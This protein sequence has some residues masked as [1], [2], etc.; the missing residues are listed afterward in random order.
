LKQWI[1][2]GAVRTTKTRGGHHRVA[3][4]E[5]E[6]LL[7]DSVRPPDHRKPPPK[8]TPPTVVALS[9]R[10]QLRGLIEEVRA[11]GI[12]AQVRMRIGDD[13][14]TAI[15][16]RDAVTALGLKR[17]QPAIALIKST[18]VMIAREPDAWPPAPPSRP[19]RKRRRTR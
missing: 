12:L 11:D 8:K 2:H 19:A 4:D 7:T 13:V 9:T 3:A 5:I 16:T 6:R 18:E 1:Y 17:G 14:L 10:N 15:I